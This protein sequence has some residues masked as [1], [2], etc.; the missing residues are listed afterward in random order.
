MVVAGSGWPNYVS[1]AFHRRNHSLS[2]DPS[3]GFLPDLEAL[4]CHPTLKL[5]MV[6]RHGPT[7]LSTREK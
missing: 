6:A 3:E 2:L 5:I 4:G 7:A 1:A